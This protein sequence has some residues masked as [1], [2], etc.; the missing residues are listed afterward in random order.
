MIVNKYGKEY[1][2]SINPFSP[3]LIQQIV[4][5]EKKEWLEDISFHLT[6]NKTNFHTT[7]QLCNSE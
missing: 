3:L 5:Q 6:V 4:K 7:I 2:L 1:E